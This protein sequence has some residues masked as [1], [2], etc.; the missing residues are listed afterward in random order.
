MSEIMLKV[1]F[2]KQIL[3]IIF[4]TLNF[5]LKFNAQESEVINQLKPCPTP[6]K[7]TKAEIKELKRINRDVEYID[8]GDPIEIFV[9][10]ETKIL[11]SEKTAGIIKFQTNSYELTWTNADEKGILVARLNFFFRITSIDKKFDSCFE[12][13]FRYSF[14]EDEVKKKI[15]I[16]YQ[17]V[18]ELPRGVYT[19]DFLVRDIE[20]GK[21]GT[22]KL[23][24]EIK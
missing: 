2:M 10:I 23:K 1:N 4:L 11:S 12:E 13:K 7:L 8:Y 20:T 6:P 16:L 18:F 24:F 19:L 15:P 17:K 9:G 5:F 14:K 21:T 22:Q 3:F